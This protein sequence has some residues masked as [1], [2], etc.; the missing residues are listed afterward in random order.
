MD[1]DERA[2]YAAHVREEQKRRQRQ[3]VVQSARAREQ[4]RA[5]AS[6]QLLE[7][8][9]HSDCDGGHPK[10]GAQSEVP[11][12]TVRV[13][14]VSDAPGEKPA[15]PPLRPAAVASGLR[16]TPFN[17]EEE[18]AFYREL[19]T[20]APHGACYMMLAQERAVEERQAAA[21]R[22]LKAGTYFVLRDGS[23]CDSR[24]VKLGAAAEVLG[25][26]L[27]EIA[28]LG[29][30]PARAVD[31]RLAEAY[32]ASK[33]RELGSRQSLGSGA[34]ASPTPPTTSAAG[35]AQSGAARKMHRK[36]LTIE[37]MQANFDALS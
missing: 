19:M 12:A 34:I 7:E 35:H 27:R 14:T 20:G 36:P 18:L 9:L 17:D 15:A 8:Q 1:A 33:A 37:Q 5:A 4:Q 2:F 11:K 28:P 26:E 25:S 6:L 3:A 29:P 30:S 10:G 21:R 32:E 22:A 24:G 16:G 31:A 13:V 23:V